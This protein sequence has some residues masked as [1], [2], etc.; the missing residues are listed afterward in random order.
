MLIF[1]S[2]KTDTKNLTEKKIDYSPVGI[3]A[4]KMIACLQFFSAEKGANSKDVACISIIKEVSEDMK[5]NRK[6][7]VFDKC[8]DIFNR[9]FVEKGIK[10]FRDMK[11]CFDYLNPRN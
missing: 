2:C 4:K 8:V 5:L 9:V 6:I 7:R 11:E 1:V 3:E 10:P